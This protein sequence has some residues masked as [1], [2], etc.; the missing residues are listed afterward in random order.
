V[1]DYT[2]RSM[3]AAFRK[4]K[5]QMTRWSKYEDVEKKSLEVVLEMRDYIK[6]GEQVL[7]ELRLG[8]NSTPTLTNSLREV[9]NRVEHYQR[10]A[11]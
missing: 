4:Y 11:N 6:E 5:R 10:T 3:D 9:G 7:E 2:G 1:L 8:N